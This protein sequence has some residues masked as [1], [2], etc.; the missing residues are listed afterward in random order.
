MMYDVVDA[1]TDNIESLRGSL[2]A[3]DASFDTSESCDEKSL[4]SSKTLP[5]RLWRSFGVICVWLDTSRVSRLPSL[6][7]HLALASRSY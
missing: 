5:T 1:R 2:Q 3:A 6:T 7:A 4:E